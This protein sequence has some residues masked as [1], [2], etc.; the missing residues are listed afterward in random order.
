MNADKN[1]SEKNQ[2]TTTTF[3]GFSDPHPS[4]KIRGQLI[5]SITKE[6]MHLAWPLL[7]RRS[8]EKSKQLA[9]F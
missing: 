4:V 1:G 5:R 8:S 3:S 7:L 2:S 9:L 6:A